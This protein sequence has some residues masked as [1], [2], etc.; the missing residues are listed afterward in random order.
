MRRGSGSIRGITAARGHSATSATPALA[1]WRH[2]VA[3][4]GAI[5]PRIIKARIVTAATRDHDPG[6]QTALVQRA[7]I[8]FFVIGIYSTGRGEAE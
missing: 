7:G 8:V 4:P 1:I 3:Q 2:S 6:L 5:R